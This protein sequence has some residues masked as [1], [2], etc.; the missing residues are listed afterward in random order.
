VVQSSRFWVAL[1]LL[2]LPGQEPRRTQG[3]RILQVTCSG[4][5]AGKDHLQLLQHAI[6]V[7][8]I[9]RQGKEPSSRE[10]HPI[11]ELFP[12]M[13]L[14]NITTHGSAERLDVMV[15]IDVHVDAALAP[16]KADIEAIVRKRTGVVAY[17]VRKE[18]IRAVERLVNSSVAKRLLSEPRFK[19]GDRLAIAYMVIDFDSIGIGA[20]SPT[21]VDSTMR[22]GRFGGF[23][24]DIQYSCK[25]LSILPGSGALRSFRLHEIVSAREANR[26]ELRPAP[27]E[28]TVVPAVPRRR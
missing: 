22:V 10:I 5:V 20:F 2:S 4:I 19:A 13:D 18:S 15:V 7:G 26:F 14:P 16:F 24:V 21:A 3:R 12:S 25:G 1:L 17:N 6:R 8:G 9:F 11:G 23:N 27:P 28:W